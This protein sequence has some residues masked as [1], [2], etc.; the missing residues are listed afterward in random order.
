MNKAIFLDRDGVINEDTGHLHKISDL[1]FY[2]DVIGSLV[3]LSKSSFKIII[4]TNQ[5]GIGK[6]YYTEDEYKEFE[7]K[8][9][10]KL[11]KDSDGKIRIDGVY[12]CP[13]HPELGVGKYKIECNCRKPSHGML[14]KAAKEH[15]IDLAKSFMIGD[16]YS[17]ISAGRKA[18]CKTI[19]VKT[20][21][22]SGN[23]IKDDNE[24]N[25]KPNYVFQDINNA[26]DF[27]LKDYSS[28]TV[29]V[30]GSS[31]FIGQNLCRRLFELNAN[32]IALD[33]VPIQIKDIKF[34]KA[35]ITDYDKLISSLIDKDIKKIDVIF[36]LAGQPFKWKADKDPDATTKLN[37]QGTI[38][39]IKIAKKYGSKLIFPSTMALYPK[40]VQPPYK[41]EDAD[42]DSFYGTS[43]FTAEKYIINSGL[44]YT[45]LRLGY[46]YG[47][48]NLNRLVYDVS[49]ALINDQNEIEIFIH[50]DSLLDILYISDVIEI[51]LEFGLNPIDGLFNVG[52]GNPIK[53]ESIISVI[54]SLFNKNPKIKLSD[55]ASD[56]FRTEYMDITKLQKAL[57]WEPIYTLEQGIQIT[58]RWLK[59]VQ[60]KA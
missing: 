44:Q 33:M 29:L 49:S 36:H 60:N 20:G 47:P 42:P 51:M 45:I 8:Y 4:I 23:I 18:G 12:Y 25:V 54:T 11:Q 14:L 58:V 9:L 37:V 3:K 16:K 15:K 41:E 2:K 35:D 32:I 38:N 31:G 28:K 43:K 56:V 13:H 39:L 57:N 17:D 6:G 40:K 55:K 10:E 26:I 53:V 30:T 34:I 52:S 1:K 19:L 21:D 7:R 46:L 24:I 50:P 48:Y 27:I 5:A 59:N 22:K